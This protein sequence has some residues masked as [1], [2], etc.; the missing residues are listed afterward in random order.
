[1]RFA[2]YPTYLGP[3]KHRR[4]RRVSFGPKR[5]CMAKTEAVAY[6][7][8][9]SDDDEESVYEDCLSHYA[10]FEHDDD[11]LLNRECYASIERSKRQAWQLRQVEP[12]LFDSE[13]Y[14]SSQVR[15]VCTYALSTT[16]RFR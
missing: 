5:T 1:M 3:R 9:S 12:G 15:K 14:A 7:H 2:D 6:C 8:D 10:G 13:E 16:S 11:E 4:S